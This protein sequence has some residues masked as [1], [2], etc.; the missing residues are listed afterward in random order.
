MTFRE[1]TAMRKKATAAEMERAGVT[2]NK[3]TQYGWL[4]PGDLLVESTDG[5]EYEFMGMYHLLVDG[6][7]YFSDDLE[8][9]E[10]ILYSGTAVGM[11]PQQH[12]K[13]EK[14][15]RISRST[16][17]SEAWRKYS[18]P[19]GCY[20]V[21]SATGSS[22]LLEIGE[23]IKRLAAFGPSNRLEESIQDE[24]AAGELLARVAIR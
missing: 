18:G 11:Q 15:G 24:E 14:T 5:W 3:E 21:F 10:R 23:Y 19:A 2:H 22:S 12:H 7:E 6:R 1:F 20:S 8:Q 4:Y 16:E 9:L 17:K 13:G